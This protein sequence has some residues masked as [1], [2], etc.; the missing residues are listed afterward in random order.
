M[1]PFHYLDLP[2]LAGEFYVELIKKNDILGRI[3][4]ALNAPNLTQE[5]IVFLTTLNNTN[6]LKKLLT[7]TQDDLE[8]YA[9]TVN[10]SLFWD[11]SRSTPFG[12]IVLDIFGYQNFR[13]NAKSKWLTEQLKIKTCPYC[14]AQYTISSKKKLYHTFDHFFPK[15]LYPYLSVS[16]Y[17][18]IP[19]CNT[20]N[21]GKSNKDVDLANHWHPYDG[22]NLMEEFQFEIEPKSASEFALD[23]SNDSILE[24]RMKPNINLSEKAKN[25]FEHFN[26]DVQYKAHTDIAAEAI[27]KSKVYTGSYRKELQDLFS[28]KNIQLTESEIKRFIIGNY[29]DP[30]DVH[31]RPLAKLTSDLAKDLGLI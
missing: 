27:W 26:L 22:T 19:A 2:T 9:S 31:K 3:A 15:S 4:N 21:Q 12:T 16:F 10:Q 13:K 6:F 14:N 1:N 8:A 11:G 20:C 30:A 24:I 5:Q 25:H 17:N 7:D 23:Y 28:T 29:A 18:L